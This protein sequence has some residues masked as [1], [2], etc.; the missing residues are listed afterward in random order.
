MRSTST[1]PPFLVIG[2][3]LKPHSVHGEMRV[4]PITDLPER[5]QWLEAVY[6]GKKSPR[7]IEIEQVRFHNHLILLKLAGFDSRDEVEQ[8]RGALLQVPESEA[9][10]L[11]EGEYFLYQLEGISVYT[12][13]DEYLGKVVEVI[14]TG[15]N[16]VFVVRGPDGETLLPDIDEVILAIDFDSE[17]MVV[18]LLPGLR[19]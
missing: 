5:F 8:F 11:A 3:I 7:L 1:E 17:R 16:N 13:Q 6:V 18:H 14:E 9:I 12:D 19:S 2:Q 10:P 15:A 4:K